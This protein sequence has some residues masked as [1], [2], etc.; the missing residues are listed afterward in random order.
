MF[1]EA[2][3]CKIETCQEVLGLVKNF[4]PIIRGFNN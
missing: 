2:K 4:V 3:L 1:D